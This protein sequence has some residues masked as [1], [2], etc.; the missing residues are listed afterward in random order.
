MN[1]TLSSNA[2]ILFTKDALLIA[3]VFFMATGIA[4]ACL[5]VIA[6]YKSK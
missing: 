6:R 3:A 2:P 1:V 4:Q 5:G